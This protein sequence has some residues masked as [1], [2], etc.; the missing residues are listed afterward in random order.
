MPIG[1]GC[2]RKQATMLRIQRSLQH[3]SLAQ[4]MN[5]HIVITRARTIEMLHCCLLI[6]R[7]GTDRGEGTHSIKAGK[8][9]ACCVT[10][11]R[12]ETAITKEMH[13]VKTFPCYTICMYYILYIF[14]YCRYSI[15]MF[16]GLASDIF[17]LPIHFCLLGVIIYRYRF[18]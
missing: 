3:L 10:E 11:G 6:H 18:H 15:T 12:D 16:R 2:P 8:G 4:P 13:C 5:H 7:V 17:C 1:P 9:M 14:I